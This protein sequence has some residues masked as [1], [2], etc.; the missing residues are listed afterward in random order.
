MNTKPVLVASPIG[1]TVAAAAL[2]ILITIGLLVAVAGLFL[3]DGT[4]LQNVVAAK[5]R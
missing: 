1:A 3:H 4:P 5:S 2:S